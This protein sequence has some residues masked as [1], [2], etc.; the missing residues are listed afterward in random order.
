MKKWIAANYPG[1]RLAIT[2]Y[3]WG[4]LDKITGAIAQADIL[5]IFG[6]EGVDL[7]TI[8]ATVPPTSPAAF[9]WRMFLDYDGQGS[10]FGAIS[11]QGAT[12]DVDTVSV[13]ASENETGT[14]TVLLLNK[15]LEDIEVPFE[16]PGLESRPIRVWRYS[17]ADLKKIVPVDDASWGDDRRAKLALPALSMTMLVLPN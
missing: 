17:E 1:T 15:S 2:E 16:A 14:V 9:A 13:F 10:G 8:W 12:T 7:A 6:R 4:A 3:N 11:V 5:G